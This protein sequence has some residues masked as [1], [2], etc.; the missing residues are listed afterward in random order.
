MDKNALKK[1]W[2]ENK[3]FKIG[4]SFLFAIQVPDDSVGCSGSRCSNCNNSV[5]YCNHR[6]RHCGFPFVGPF[7][8][9]QIFVWE[10]LSPEQ[11]RTIVED[12]YAH[13]SNR[14]RLLYTNV[15]PVPL[16]P[17]ELR[18]IERLMHRDA[19]YFRSTHSISPKKIRRT[20]F[21]L[22]R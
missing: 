6:C 21:T 20:L 17:K 3:I 2:E 10:T 15:E 9:P 14:G 8:F 18:E 5:A 16:T 1:A 13:H 19:D 12:I 11:K 22:P 4:R 7:G